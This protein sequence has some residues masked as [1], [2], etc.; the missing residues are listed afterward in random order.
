[1][2]AWLR[3]PVGMWS[4][5]ALVVLLFMPAILPELMPENQA[6]FWLGNIFGR[7]IIFGII[8]MSLTF[9]ATY[10]GFVS[11][12]QMSVAGVAGYVLAVTIDGAAPSIVGGLG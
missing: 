1:M 11:L 3:T 5:G 9:L 2:I 12:A 4:A 8:A 7:G 10:G 6:N